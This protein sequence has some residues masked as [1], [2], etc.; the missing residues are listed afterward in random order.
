MIDT[1][2][3]TLVALASLI[4]HQRSPQ[5]VSEDSWP[6]IVQLALRHGLGPMLLWTIR[7]WGID[8]KL[9]SV[10][11]PLIQTARQATIHD[12]LLEN[13]QAQVEAALVK[14][15][16]PALWL[17]GFALARTIY[18][19]S[20]LRPM[21]D[22]D[23]LVP[24]KQRELALKVC[25]S[26]GYHLQIH[27][28]RLFHEGEALD[29]K[30]MHH[31]YLRGGV[32]DSVILELHFHLLGSAKSLLPLEKLNWF[33]T[34]T[35]NL[36]Q[37][38]TSLT[39]LKPEAHL[40]YL[41]AH[42]ILQHGE[43]QFRLI[44]Y[45]D[46]HLLIT[47][48]NLDWQFVID[49]AVALRWTYAVERALTLT[50]RFF[51]TPVPESVFKQLRDRRPPEENLFHVIALQDEGIRWEKVMTILAALPVREKFGLAFRIVLPPPTFMRHRYNVSSNRLIWPYYF[52]RW[53]DQTREVGAWIWNRLKRRS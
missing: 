19:R 36:T 7:Q 29:L 4:S 12:M 32:A 9:N 38:K 39:I 2:E 13:T 6:D 27:P 49:Q 11:A 22:L 8:T 48:A 3:P 41:I 47:S 37:D 31:H 52:S 43:I 35:Q 5:S 40:L 25:E 17:K 21:G 45:F 16:I 53:F 44:W 30:V 51:K 42:V 24:Y 15:A 1:S 10:W 50:G 20:T 28:G 46:L 34:Q 23:V 26:I 18:P 14:A 33:W